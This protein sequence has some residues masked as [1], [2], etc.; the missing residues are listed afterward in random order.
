M[1]EASRQPQIVVLEAGLLAIARRLFRGSS[2]VEHPTVNRTV[3][4]SSP[5]HGA[6]DF[7]TLDDFATASKTVAT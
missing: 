4:G 7:K 5:T 6:N 1:T 2:V 3:V